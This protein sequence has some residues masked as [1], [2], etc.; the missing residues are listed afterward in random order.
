MP[1]SDN[2]NWLMQCMMGRENMPKT[3]AMKVFIIMNPLE[4]HFISCEKFHAY[5]PTLS[6]R[7][8]IHSLPRLK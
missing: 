7:C 5:Y 3:Y 6:N 2:S 4:Y 8:S 1:S